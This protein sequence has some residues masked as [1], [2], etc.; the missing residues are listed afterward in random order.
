MIRKKAGG[1]FM[2]RVRRQIGCVDDGPQWR[3]EKICTVA[4]LDTGV[5][6]HPDL[7]GRILDFRDFVNSKS[8]IYDDSGHG[9][10]VCGIACGSGKLSAGRYRGISPLSNLI[11]GKVLDREGNGTVEAMIEGIKWVL[12]TREKYGVRILNISIGTGQLDDKDRE[13][14][15]VGWLETAWDA[16]LLVVCAAGNGGP[17][18][19][20]ISSLGASARLI[21]VGCHDGEYYRNMPNRCETYSGRG[22]MLSSVRK[23][24]VVAPGTEIISC[25]AKCRMG[26]RGHVHAYTSKSGTSMATPIVSGALALLLQQD[27][28]CR[29]ELAKKKLLYSATDMGEAWYKQGYGMLNVKKLLG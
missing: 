24:D 23:P 28:K 27:P 10:H 21:T 18:W 16:G 3:P 15:L 19:N 7:A 6:G 1:L 20:T 13:A 9:T 17:Q 5:A 14:A 29:N 22:S 8:M 25:D 4:V 11:V 26:R 2:F 12:D